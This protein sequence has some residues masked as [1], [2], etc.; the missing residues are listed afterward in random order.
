MNIS[1]IAFEDDCP[2]LT[3]IGTAFQSLGYVSS[4]SIA[5]EK[6]TVVFKMPANVSSLVSNAFS[7][8]RAIKEIVFADENKITTIPDGAFMSSGIESITIPKNVTSI[9]N[10]TSSRAAF[11]ACDNLTS[12]VFEEGGT[13]DVTIG[14]YVFA[15]CPKLREVTLSKKV[16]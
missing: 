4:G 5:V 1:S 10:G 16:K 14:N 13:A 6:A 3:S 2:N 8:A 12:V 11:R 15:Y 7:N 9:T